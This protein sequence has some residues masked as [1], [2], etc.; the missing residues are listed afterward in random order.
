[1][2]FVYGEKPVIYNNG[3]NA[4]EAGEWPG[5]KSNKFENTRQIIRQIPNLQNLDS[6]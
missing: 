2:N 1:M 4:K 5:I 3:V 6:I